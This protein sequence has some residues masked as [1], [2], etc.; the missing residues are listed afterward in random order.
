MKPG[1]EEW[2]LRCLDGKATVQER[3]AWEALLR[4]DP[5]ARAYLRE[6]AEQAVLLADLERTTSENFSRADLGVLSSSSTAQPR[7]KARWA[8]WARGAV[9][10]AALLALLAVA[11]S[12][13]RTTEARSKL[14]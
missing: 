13:L 12:W 9:A 3:E 10:A 6:L 11:L 2:M 5:E 7:H 14:A 4:D 8:P 1:A